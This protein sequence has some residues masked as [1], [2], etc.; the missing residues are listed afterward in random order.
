MIEDNDK[1]RISGRKRKRTQAAIDSEEQ[2]GQSEREYFGTLGIDQV[3]FFDQHHAKVFEDSET[4]Q[5][6]IPIDP[7]TGRA[8]LK[9]KGGV[10]PPMRPRK[11]FKFMGEIRADLGMCAPTNK[12]TGES[13][14]THSEI[15]F[16]HGSGQ[17]KL[18]YAKEY[19]GLIRDEIRRAKTLKGQWARFA[20]ADNPYKARWPDDWYERIK[21]CSKMSQKFDVRDLMLWTKNQCEKMFKGSTHE[22]DWW[23]MRDGLNQWWAKE[24]QD[25]AK[26]IGLF[27]HQLQG[28]GS[29]NKG[30]RY[31][32]K[33]P[34]DQHCASPLDDNEFSHFKRLRGVHIGATVDLPKDDPEKFSMATPSLGASCFTRVWESMDPAIA[35]A[36]ILRWPRNIKKIVD[37]QG[38]L[39]QKA[40]G[41]GHRQQRAYCGVMHKDAE[42]AMIKSEE[43]FGGHA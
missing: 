6:R 12:A 27:K 21:K 40:A 37:N 26:E 32:G 8:E 28:F 2:G 25:Y 36:N 20:N 31:E 18:C 13:V 10:M 35:K 5:T 19:D 1:P 11:K 33:I 43:K 24:A 30:T 4:H 34:G 16:Y 17:G 9:H 22:D 38:M 39:V 23:V 3:A 42:S 29:T 7:K 15:F 41:G 14:G